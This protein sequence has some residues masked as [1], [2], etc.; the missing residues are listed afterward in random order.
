MTASKKHITLTVLVPAYNE[1]STIRKILDRLLSQPQVSQVVVVNDAS[2]D[3]TGAIVRGIKDKRLTLISH[4]KNMG[5]GKAIQT[6]LQRATGTYVL[7]QD[8]DM[9]YDPGE[10][11]LLLEPIKIGRAEIVYGSRFF[12]AHTNMFFWHYIGNQL[13][14]LA[15]NVLYNSI[16]SDMETCYKLIPTDL[17][18]S[19]DLKEND[20]RIEPEITCK[21]LQGNNKIFEVPITYVG[22]TYEE[23]K[24]ITWVDW[25]YAIGT[26]IRIRFLG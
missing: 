3:R 8:A 18:R 4:K 25:F 7:I 11:P 1:E 16:V 17:L 19:L 13:L 24:K 10:I 26:I 12:G 20:F 15:V 23:G 22:R 9:E 21:I 2:T 5:K 6:G 14:N